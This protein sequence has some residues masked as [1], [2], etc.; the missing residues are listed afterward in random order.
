[1]PSVLTGAHDEVWRSSKPGRPRYRSTIQGVARPQS[2]W[3]N[4]ARTALR[5]AWKLALLASVVLAVMCVRVFV[6]EY[7]HGGKE[8]VHQ[9]FD[10]LLP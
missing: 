3:A 6:F 9:L 7:T 8:V 5:L 10:F 1:M 4:A 2:P